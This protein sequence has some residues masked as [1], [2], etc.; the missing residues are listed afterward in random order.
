[1]GTKL[2]KIVLAILF[3]LPVCANATNITFTSD[4][5]IQAGDSWGNVYIHDTLPAHTTVTMTGGS[6]TDSMTVYDASKFNM[7][8]GYLNSLSA[9]GSNTINVYGGSVNGLGSADA[10]VIFSLR[11]GSVTF[12]NTDSHA[13]VNIYGYNLAKTNTGGMFGYGQITGFWQDNSQF[14]INLV[15]SGTYSSINLIPEPATLLL[16]GASAFILRK[17]KRRMKK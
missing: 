1:M 3:L 11:G 7:Y 2:L 10:A 17:S 13:A 12:I 9:H 8:A 5:N 4:A 16:F 6:V 15:G 14:T